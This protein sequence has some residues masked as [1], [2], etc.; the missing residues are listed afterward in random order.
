MENA[1]NILQAQ[2]E[3]KKKS[4]DFY[5][6]KAARCARGSAAYN[7]YRMAAQFQEGVITGI[8]IAIDAIK[9]AE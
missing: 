7:E 3:E 1:L 5:D 2:L 8:Q 6:N 9:G 4:R